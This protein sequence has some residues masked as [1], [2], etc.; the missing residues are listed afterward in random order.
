MGEKRERERVGEGGGER[1]G[2]ERGKKKK[3]KRERETA[4]FPDRPF[5]VFNRHNEV[6][7][8]LI[9]TAKGNLK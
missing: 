5:S 9:L 8:A 1:E 4:Y 3:E 6:P 7:F 2:R